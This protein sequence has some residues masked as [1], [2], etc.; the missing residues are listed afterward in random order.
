MPFLH[1]FLLLKQS[2]NYIFYNIYSQMMEI[3]NNGKTVF[4]NYL[5]LI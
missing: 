4:P 2:R 1:K 3:K 5:K